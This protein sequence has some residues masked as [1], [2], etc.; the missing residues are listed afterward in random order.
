MV[1]AISLSANG[2]IDFG[3]LR[4]FHVHGQFCIYSPQRCGPTTSFILDHPISWI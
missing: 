1:S 4:S 3:D 2:V